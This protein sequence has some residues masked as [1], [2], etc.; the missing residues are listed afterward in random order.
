[1]DLFPG[2]LK[3]AMHNLSLRE[4]VRYNSFVDL[5][6][7]QTYGRGVFVGVVALL[8]AWRLT[9]EAA[10]KVAM[11]YLPT[12]TDTNC[13]PECWRE[14]YNTIRASENSS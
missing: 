12:D 14:K 2:V 3:D 1:M 7:G 10:L 4:T 6:R 8:I 5:S 9:F 13:I 11:K